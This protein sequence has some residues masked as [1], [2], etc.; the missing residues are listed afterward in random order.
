MEKKKE[1]NKG[2]KIRRKPKSKI[3]YVIIFSLVLLISTTIVLTG[4]TFIGSNTQEINRMEDSVSVAEAEGV[5]VIDLATNKKLADS[6]YTWSLK[7]NKNTKIEFWNFSEGKLYNDTIIMANQSEWNPENFI[8]PKS[9]N[10]SGKIGAWIYNVGTYEGE[11]INLKCTFYWEN[12]KD[13]DEDLVPIIGIVPRSTRSE[14]MIGFRFHNV[15]YRVK[16]EIFSGTG[17]KPSTDKIAL[18]MS[19]TFGDIDGGQFFG[20]KA[21]ENGSIHLKQCITGCSVQY[22]RDDNGYEWFYSIS[23]IPEDDRPEDSVRF[24]LENLQ[25]FE[26][27]YGYRIIYSYR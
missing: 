5:D 2:S 1:S 20:F 27:I 14:K 11:N 19:M 9:N 16:Y 17:N 24:E 15:A 4:R 7:A 21:L 26:V 18:D 6:K 22:Q 3:S 8:L 23:T 13:G 12:I 10:L 25:A